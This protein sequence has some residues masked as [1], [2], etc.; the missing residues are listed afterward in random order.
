MR[1]IAVLFAACACLALPAL[2]ETAAEKGERIARASSEGESGFSDFTVEGEMILFSARGATSTR[3]FGMRTVENPTDDGSRSLLIF[4][5]PGDIRNTALLT[6]SFDRAADDQWLY[7]PAVGKVRRISGSGRAG[8]FVGS[9][10]AYEDMLDQ[11][12]DEFTHEWLR[13]EACPANP[14]TCD[15][16]DRRARGSSSYSLQRLWIDQR[17]RRVRA[18]QYFD[19]RGAHLKTLAMAEYRR[20]ENRYW[21]PGLMV[22]TNHLTGKKTELRWSGHRFNQGANA[23]DF[24]PNA[25]RNIR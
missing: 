5:W 21:R 1:L 11:N 10:F 6:H 2:A 22:M 14:L 16:I 24:T 17:D 19:R 20:H 8:S 7:L 4:E 12:V 9:E 3:R 25:L 15:V 18:V 23:T 13:A